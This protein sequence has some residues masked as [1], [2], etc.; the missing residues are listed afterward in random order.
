MSEINLNRQA[1]SFTREQSIFKRKADKLVKEFIAP[2]AER[3][4]R[5]GRFP[6]ENMHKLGEVGLLGLGIRK[7]FGGIGGDTLATTLV[8]ESIAKGCAS[9][10]MSYLMHIST[11]P[12]FN[13][14]VNEQQVEQFLKTIN[15]KEN[16]LG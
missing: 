12:L 10:A 4:D 1:L 7:E 14:L 5:E 13:A 8:I 16:S 3:T 6:I 15:G 9:T 11:I 2:S